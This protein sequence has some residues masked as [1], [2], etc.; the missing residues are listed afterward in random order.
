[1]SAYNDQLDVGSSTR[2]KGIQTPV[3]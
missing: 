1:M 3:K 2:S